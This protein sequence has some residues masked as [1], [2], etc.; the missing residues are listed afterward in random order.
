MYVLNSYFVISLAF[1]VLSEQ[2]IYVSRL[3]GHDTKTCG[4]VSSPCRTIPYSIQQ[5]STGVHIYLDGT[6]T[7][8]D[9]YT[10][11]GLDPRHPR[12]LLTKSVSFVSI[13]SR[14]H[15][16]CLY[17]NAW[18]ASG[19]EHKH[20][21]RTSFSGLAFFNTLVALRDVFLAVD[22]TIFAGTK[23]VNLYIEG[24]KLPR[25]D[26]SLNNVVFKKN[27][28][29][30]MIEPKSSKVFIN[31]TNTVFHQ[32]GDLFSNMPSIIW[33]NCTNNLINIQ[34]RN[35]SFKKNMKTKYGMI[36]V[37][38]KLG[39]TNILLDQLKLEEIGQ[40]SGTDV[41]GFVFLISSA[42]VFM[43]LKYGFIFK[44]SAT[45]LCVI[46]QSAEINISNIEV[47]GYYSGKL[48]GGVVDLIQNESCFLSIKD[49]SFRN[50]NNH[51]SGGV[52]YM[53]AP[54]SMLT[55]Q[56][57]TTYNIS[58]SDWGGA[59]TILSKAKKFK[60]STKRRKK[61]LCSSTHNQFF[62]FIHLIR[63]GWW[64]CMGIH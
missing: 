60:Q 43:S 35:C 6:D 2:A 54:N 12:I 48:G 55:I 38:N 27:S 47:D 44:I 21:I 64:C 11:E 18:Y 34:L 14:A 62:V 49:S 46:S 29:C 37:K 52:I 7:L 8:K 13:K 26:L 63:E 16:S 5:L 39:T 15:I 40:G 41:V 53:V 30:M 22:D 31:I 9:P 57:S 42:R 61:I 56:N 59:V 3:T 28:G 58:S 33:L 19:N 4:N 1:L 36:T 17:G 51:D 10:C 32:N 20:G 25:F 45:F 50:G 24:V 23:P